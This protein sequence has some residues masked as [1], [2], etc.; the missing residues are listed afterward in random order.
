MNQNEYHILSFLPAYQS[1]Q[2]SPAL[3]HLAKR[4]QLSGRLRINADH[5]QN[6]VN[7]S[8]P[9]FDKSFSKR[10][11]LDPRLVERSRQVI[12]D[13]VAP[14]EGEAGI[15]AVI[16]RLLAEFKRTSEIA[17]ERE[18]QIARLL[19]QA[20]YPSV[21]LLAMY[22]GVNIYVSYS[23]NVAD[24]MGVH[25]WEDEGLSGG[26]Q[27][28]S[29][30]GASVYISC[31][32][33][34]FVTKDEQR[35][36]E[37]DGFPALARLLVIAAQELAHYADI[38]RNSAGQQIGRHSVHMYPFMAKEGVRQARIK[39]MAHMTLVT[40]QVGGCGLATLMEEEKALTFYGEHRKM[41]GWWQK[42]KVATAR[43]AFIKRAC[44]ASLSFVI[45]FPATLYHSEQMGRNVSLCLSDMM[46]N[47]APKAD[48]YQ[49][50]DAVEEEAIAC[51]EALARVPQQV[52]KWGHAVTRHAWPNLYR[53][54]YEQVIPATIR[55]FERISGESYRQ[56]VSASQQKASGR[57][58]HN[59]LNIMNKNATS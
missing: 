36:Y 55:D 18:L 38:E 42:Q 40:Q 46:F 13:T 30:D 4:L 22:E 54:Y 53:I 25:F 23:H 29:G 58:L 15:D 47:L 31:G 26:L 37:T 34:P 12:A 20:T 33:D 1:D 32:G 28:V 7:Y 16:Q 11:L 41:A 51:V 8:G 19:V 35:T 59:I 56:V 48:V 52:V 44:A 49:R 14:S 5:A 9:G 6:Y 45:E 24:L 43:N 10:E 57:K 17:V 21:M 50:D 3:E 39:D 27:K 2:L